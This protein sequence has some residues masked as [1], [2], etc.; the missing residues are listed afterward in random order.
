MAART[1]L[2][3]DIPPEAEDGVP[4]I[5]KSFPTDS[6]DIAADRSITGWLNAMAHF[7]YHIFGGGGVQQQGRWTFLVMEHND[8]S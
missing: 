7:G 8:S 2:N 1:V 5:F 4:Y 6:V 3:V